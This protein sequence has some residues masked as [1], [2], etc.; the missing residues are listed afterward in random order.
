MKRTQTQLDAISQDIINR[1]SGGQQ[2]AD[3]LQ[4][5][6]ET[7]SVCEKTAYNWT[8]RAYA[9]VRES[10]SETEFDLS[11]NL[12]LRYEYLYKVALDAQR[13]AECRRILAELG[14]V[15]G[16]DHTNQWTKSGLPPTLKVEMI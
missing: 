12:Y 15:T 4:Y 3:I 10:L 8:R 13:Y 9:K 11:V 6:T 7:H 5:L 16:I 2:H 1:I 14:K